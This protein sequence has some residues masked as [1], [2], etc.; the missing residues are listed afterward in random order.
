LRVVALRYFNVA[1]AEPQARIGERH[2]PETHLI[3]LVLKAA[4]GERDAITVFG[5]DYSTVDGTCI[6]D[7]IH[8][9]DLASAH[10]EALRHLEANGESSILNVGYGRGFSV[11]EVIEI[12]SSV[13]GMHLPV[14]EAARRPGDPPVLIAKADRIRGLFGWKPR[15]DDLRTIVADAWH[16]ERKKNA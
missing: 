8:V 11:K 7:Y 14:R 1:G 13:T 12:A 9:E 15:Y 10:L 5:T 6:R 2:S 16:W 4:T 3:P